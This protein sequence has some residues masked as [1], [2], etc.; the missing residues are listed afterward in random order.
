M[1]C[2]GMS[3]ASNNIAIK[4]FLFEIF[5]NQLSKTTSLVVPRLHLTLKK[6]WN[7]IVFLK[8][9]FPF[10]AASWPMSAKTYTN[11]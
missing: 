2:G 10:G 7:Y 9:L 11:L 3:F 8:S 6:D 4:I 1:V 5:L